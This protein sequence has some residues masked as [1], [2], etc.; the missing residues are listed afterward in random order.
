ME[1]EGGR[2]GRKRLSR[3]AFFPST[4]VNHEKEQQRKASADYAGRHVPW[5]RYRSGEKPLHQ[6]VG[7]IAHGH[8][9]NDDQ[10][11]LEG[12]VHH[13]ENKKHEGDCA[14]V[15]SHRVGD[16]KII[17]TRT[18]YERPVEASSC[19][20]EGEGKE[21]HERIPGAALT[22]GEKFTLFQ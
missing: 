7:D 18:V 4:L 2:V 14:K 12:G 8:H 16:S 15:V 11:F 13:G 5:V 22:P 1:W 6:F 3:A 19:L 20:G 10:A 9:G 21:K 17:E